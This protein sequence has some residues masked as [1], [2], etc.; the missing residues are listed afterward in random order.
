MNIGIVGR[1]G[2]TATTFACTGTFKGRN[3][4]LIKRTYMFIKF[5][6]R[7]WKIFP[8]IPLSTNVV[9]CRHHDRRHVS[10]WVETHVAHIHPC[11]LPGYTPTGQSSVASVSTSGYTINPQRALRS[12]TLLSQN[13]S[14]IGSLRSYTPTKTSRCRFSAT[15]QRGAGEQPRST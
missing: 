11:P 15:S 6:P 14:A 8:N 1:R 10:H 7:Q 9:M 2:I 13:S 4:G 5:D 12:P 3:G